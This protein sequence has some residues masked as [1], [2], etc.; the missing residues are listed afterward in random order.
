MGCMHQ[1]P[2]VYPQHQKS[3]QFLTFPEFD[4]EWCF[5]FQTREQR[6]HLYILFY[7][8]SLQELFF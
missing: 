3:F 5:Y 6:V 8:S 7:T 1:A 4:I 2:L